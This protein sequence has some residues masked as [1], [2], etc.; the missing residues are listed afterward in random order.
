MINDTTKP[1]WLFRGLI[2]FSLLVHGVLFM[3]I[4]GLYR[5][6]PMSYLEL[7]MRSVDKPV[8]RKSRAPAAGRP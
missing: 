6:R 5:P 7:S 3:H 2:L 8:A 1:N 4:A